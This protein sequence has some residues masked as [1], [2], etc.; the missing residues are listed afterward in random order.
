MA[1]DPRGTRL[2]IFGGCLARSD[3]RPIYNEDIV[4]DAD[5]RWTRLIFGL[6]VDSFASSPRHNE[7]IHVDVDPS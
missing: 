5:P 6:C 7:N 4:M 1:G 3:S 2:L